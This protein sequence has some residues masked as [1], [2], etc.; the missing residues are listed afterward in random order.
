MAQFGYEMSGPIKK[1]QNLLLRS[2]AITASTSRTIDQTFDLTV[3]T[4]RLVRSLSLFRPDSASPLVIGGT[5]ITRNSTL[6]VDPEP[7][8]PVVPNCATAISLR[9]I[10][11]YNVNVGRTT[12][13]SPLDPIGQNLI[14][15][16]PSQTD[17]GDPVTGLNNYTKKLVES[18]P[19]YQ[20]DIRIDHNFNA[21][22][23]MFG[24][25]LWSD[26]NTLKGDPLNGRPQVYPDNPPLGEVFRRTS[27]LALSYRR[28]I[29]PRIVN[30]LTG[31]YGRF[32]FV[33]RAKQIRWPDVLPW[34]FNS[35]SELYINTP[36][37]A[38]W[39]TTPQVLDTEYRAARTCFASVSI[40]AYRHVDRQLG[41]INVT[42]SVTFSK[43]RVGFS[44]DDRQFRVRYGGGYKFDRRDESRQSDQ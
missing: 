41:G 25:Y 21:N 36:R 16:Y 6:L 27:N 20:Y 34:D 39:V 26:Y 2:M 13:R 43:P 10:R 40:A 33:H 42:P 19:G 37:T 17:P 30:E 18:G 5:T 4:I 35:P 23:S 38:R 28:V 7:G 29:S 3:Y 15:L 8:V 11:T 32:G 14:K 1:K 12:P 24:R 9:C 31:G 22:N 44:R